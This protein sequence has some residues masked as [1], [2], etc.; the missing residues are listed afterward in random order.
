MRMTLN[1]MDLT[2]KY[3]HIGASFQ[4]TR[5][6]ATQEGSQTIESYMGA[7]GSSVSTVLLVKNVQNKDLIL[8]ATPNPVSQEESR[9]HLAIIKSML[10]PV[11]AWLQDIERT[12]SCAGTNSMFTLCC[13]ILSSLAAAEGN[14]HTV[15]CFDLGQAEKALRACLDKT[16][17]DLLIYASY[18]NSDGPHLLVPKLSLLIAVMRHTGIRTVETVQCVGSCAGLLCDT[19][20]W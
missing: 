4:V 20:H 2:I 13:S 14:P 9:A 19:R 12:A 15:S 18:P 1:P 5:A 3:C 10:G 8:G 16:D 6:C 7:L 17:D 11:P